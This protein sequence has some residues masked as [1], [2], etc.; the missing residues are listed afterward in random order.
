MAHAKPSP[1]DIPAL[2]AIH[3]QSEYQK[4]QKAERA[5]LLALVTSKE[6]MQ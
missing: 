3:D 5:A 1:A 2:Q 4:A 6:A